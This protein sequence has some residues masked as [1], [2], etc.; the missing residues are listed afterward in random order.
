M[1][2]NFR[3]VFYLAFPPQKGVGFSFARPLLF[4]MIK[5]TMYYIQD[6]SLF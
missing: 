1:N 3:E 4:L 2:Y 5:I 6:I